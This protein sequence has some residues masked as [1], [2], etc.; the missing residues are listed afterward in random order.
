MHRLGR[1]RLHA[2]EIEAFQ[3][4][5]DLQGGDAARGRRRHGADAPR[6]IGAAQDIAFFGAV[7]GEVGFGHGDRA[8][9]RIGDRGGDVGCDGAAMERIGAAACDTAERRRQLPVD[10]LRGE[11][12]RGAVGRQEIGPRGLEAGQPLAVAP[13]QAVQAGGDFEARFG[14]ADGG[15]EQCRPGQ[16]AVSAVDHLQHAQHARHPGRGAADQPVAETQRAGLGRD[17]HV[18]GCR[19][20]RDLAPVIGSEL[21][22]PAGSGIAR[23]VVQQERTAA[24]ARALRLDQGQHHLRRDDGVHR[25][26]AVAQHFETG[27]GGVRIGG[28]DGVA[29]GQGRFDP[30]AAR[31]QCQRQ[32]RGQ[33]DAAMASGDIRENMSQASLQPRFRALSMPAKH[34]RSQGN[35]FATGK[36]RVKSSAFRGNR[37]GPP[38]CGG[39]RSN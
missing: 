11:R 22:G 16:P 29:L 35:P 37:A 7:G 5:E 17:E 19:H 18:G 1:A 13:H 27:A 10:Q 36:I 24:N 2:G 28:G 21:R 26:A 23:R 31:R 6:P 25:A 15:A 9:R 4:G 39:R 8:V 3:H 20:R 30:G 33:S 12:L 32:G 34:P 14:E 38:A